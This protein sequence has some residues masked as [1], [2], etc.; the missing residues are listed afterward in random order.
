MGW[1]LLTVKN[2]AKYYPET[3]K[4]QKGH[5]NQTRKNVRSMKP[6]S[7]TSEGGHKKKSKTTT[8]ADAISQFKVQNRGPPGPA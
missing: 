8:A 5:M 1:P 3:V 7:S 6:N 4:T 2:I